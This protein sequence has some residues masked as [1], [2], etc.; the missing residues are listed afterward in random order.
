MKLNSPFLLFYSFCL[1]FLRAYTI[2]KRRHFLWEMGK[3]WR[4]GMTKKPSG[5]M[6]SAK[7][8]RRAGLFTAGPV[9]GACTHVCVFSGGIQT[10]CDSC[11]FAIIPSP[12]S[13]NPPSLPVSWPLSP[14]I[15]TD[16]LPPG[17]CY[18]TFM[19][20]RKSLSLIRCFT[21]KKK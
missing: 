5:G 13:Q 7:V 12:D 9:E 11:P 18:A 21:T 20:D 14:L 2:S 15:S 3:S 17:I 19:G 16:L 10:S 8:W 6:L 4:T 1:F